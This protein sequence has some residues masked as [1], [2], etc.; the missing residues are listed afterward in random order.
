[1]SLE[2]LRLEG[3][4]S[5]GI[6]KALQELRGESRSQPDCVPTT[7][8]EAQMSRGGWWPEL[9][10][11]IERRTAHLLPIIATTNMVGADLETRSPR[12]CGGA[13]VRRLRE[14]CEAIVF[15]GGRL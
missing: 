1:M 3:T 4:D 13:M 7:S 5:S 9:F 12:D 15:D 10:A 11:L 14:F 2:G 8:P 6:C